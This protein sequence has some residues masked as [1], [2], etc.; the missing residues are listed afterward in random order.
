MDAELPAFCLP[1]KVSQ[2][3]HLS[4]SARRNMS[5]L[6]HELKEFQAQ[7]I[8]CKCGIWTA[9]NS[10]PLETFSSL[11][12]QESKLSLFSSCLFLEEEYM[13]FPFFLFPVNG[14]H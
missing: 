10:F 11:D 14:L 13:Y 6:D 2:R 1:V 9:I 5:L 8:R 7:S 3:S 12:L 4:E